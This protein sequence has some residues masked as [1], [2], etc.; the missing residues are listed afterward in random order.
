MKKN[1]ELTLRAGNALSKTLALGAALTICAW[2]PGSALATTVCPTCASPTEGLEVSAFSGQVDW[3]TVAQSGVRFA[4]A[5]ATVGTSFVDPTFATNWAGIAAAGLVRG[6]YDWFNAG[7]DAKAQADLYLATVGSFEAGDLPPILL[8]DS[9][10]GSW[11]AAL[12]AKL[13]TWISTVRTATG[14]NPILLTA[15][16]IWNGSGLGNE[17]F[18]LDL[19]VASWGVA[20]P[21]LPTAW[22]GWQFW[23]YA[24]SANVPGVPG[25]AMRDRFNGT[26]EQFLAYVKAQS[27]VP[28]PA[29]WVAM[30]SGLTGLGLGARRRRN[31]DGSRR[32]AA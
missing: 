21:N 14:L 1:S 22:T 32:S 27:T 5:K 15:P 7:Q 8:V 31:A 17:T 23:N 26:D 13:D 10:S 16:A 29:A 12:H 4:I 6:A 25:T 20:C 18:G 11:G 3:T 30:L 28:V 9:A 24:E 19:W 2:L